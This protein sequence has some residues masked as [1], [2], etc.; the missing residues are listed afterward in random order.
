M[1]SFLLRCSPADT[2]AYFAGFLSETH[3]GRHEIRAS[4]WGPVKKGI[5]RR[6]FEAAG[7]AGGGFMTRCTVLRHLP[8]VQTS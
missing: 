3:V 5:E 4:S 1:P 8:L 6:G 2:G 7:D